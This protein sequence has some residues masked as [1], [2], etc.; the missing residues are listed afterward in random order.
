MKKFRKQ[1]R[2]DIHSGTKKAWKLHALYIFAFGL[3]TFVLVNKMQLMLEAQNEV[4]SWMDIVYKYFE[5]QKPF[6]GQ[7]SNTKFDM[8]FYWFLFH[9][10]SLF[11][12]VRYPRWD[13]T[14]R[15]YQFLLRSRSKK[16][17]WFSKCVWT[18]FETLLYL[19]IFYSVIILVA[20]GY[21]C[22]L[23]WKAK[24]IYGLQLQNLSNIWLFALFI[25]LPFLV[26]AAK[27]LVVLM[28]SFLWNDVGAIVCSIFI[29]IAEA[30][31]E[32]PFF[33][34]NYNMLCRYATQE[35]DVKKMIIEGVVL[36]IVAGIA[37][38]FA[39][40]QILLRKEL[41]IKKD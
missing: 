20:K 9:I 21:N 7:Q 11:L 23:S 24:N 41:I 31:W 15:G 28:L 8:P 1:I 36:S 5:G 30:Y 33:L 4:C 22:S 26:I 16:N 39:G 19:V 12:I 27:S 2:Y 35:T 34:G 3:I 37:S 18:I 38:C 29:L 10:G 14:E 32:T 13:Y 40:Y 17:W 6:T 25:G